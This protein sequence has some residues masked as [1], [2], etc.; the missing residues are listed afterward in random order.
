MWRGPRHASAFT[1]EGAL[2]PRL[3]EPLLAL[4]RGLDAFGGALFAVGFALLFLLL[5]GGASVLSAFVPWRVPVALPFEA[6]LPFVPEM[7]AVYLSMNVLLG[8]APF[9][10]RRWREM[11]T[12]FAVLATQTAI[13]AFFFLL[14][15][16]ETSFPE[17]SADGLAGGVLRIADAVNLERNFLPSLHVAFAVT[18][19]WAYAPKLGRFGR[20][21]VALWAG[22][23]IASTVLI[24]EHHLLDVLTGIAL[25]L[26]IIPL[27]ASRARR[28][29]V[30]RAV[31]VELLCLW[32]FALFSRRHIRYAW[33]ALILLAVSL[34]RWRQR[35]VLRTGFC[36]LQWVDDLLD[37]DRPSAREP[38]EVVEGLIPLL[39][40]RDSDAGQGAP[41]LHR[42]AHAFA[43]DLGAVGGEP[44]LAE[45]I[46]LLK[47]MQQDRRR[48][49]QSTLWDAEALRHH[50]RLTFTLSLDL[51]LTATR[52]EVRAE[53][54]P[55]LIDAFG[56]CSTV[57]D[58]KEDLH[59]GL[60]N[61]PREVVEAAG[62][63]LEFRALMETE[64]VQRWLREERERAGELLA[65]TTRRLEALEGKKGVGI[66]RIFHRSIGKYARRSAGG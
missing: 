41:P 28:T 64:A 53:D 3:R 26:I 50:H 39:E 54:V 61:L 43:R 24:H 52:A 62:T 11:W 40:S 9:L 25:P 21:V 5:Y 15:P 63:P 60:V 18:M 37:G 22:A 57:R 19:V 66:L 12:L 33:I 32:N 59:A 46:A 49:L 65:A 13:G 48:V 6:S 23:I 35:R 47:V 16:V 45:A 42:L 34:P 2:P 27:V 51:L 14:L 36:F 38:L 4:P 8:A 1:A 20:T 44:A 30:Q 55:E 31:E 10:L 58:L 56:W 7:A 17:R 29:R